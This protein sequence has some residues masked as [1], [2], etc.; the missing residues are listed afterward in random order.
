MQISLNKFTSKGFPLYLQ[1]ISE[2]TFDGRIKRNYMGHN[3]VQS[4]FII[5]SFFKVDNLTF[6]STLQI[7]VLDMQVCF[8]YAGVTHTGECETEH[9]SG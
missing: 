4:K 6:L 8:G 1:N 2:S 5:S 9:A 7:S 3:I